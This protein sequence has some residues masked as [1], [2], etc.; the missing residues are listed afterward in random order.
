MNRARDARWTRFGGDDTRPVDHGVAVCRLPRRLESSGKFFAIARRD[1]RGA[2]HY[3]NNIRA[4]LSLDSSRRAL[5][6]EVAR[7][8]VAHLR[9]LNRHSGSR[10]CDLES[11]GLV[12]LACDLSGNVDWFGV[13]D[14]RDRIRR[15]APLEMEYCSRRTR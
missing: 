1:A 12:W 5:H 11:R 14:L 10:R 2:H 8:R 15:N 13:H 7:E 4:V 3:L 9:S 6:R